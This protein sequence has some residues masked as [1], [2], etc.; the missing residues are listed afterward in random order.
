MSA[1]KYPI[2]V[3]LSLLCF[4]LVI[5]NKKKLAVS[6]LFFSLPFVAA[7]FKNSDLFQF[8]LGL[9]AFMVWSIWLGQMAHNVINNRKSINWSVLSPKLNALYYFLVIGALVA[10]YKGGG[11][12][13]TYGAPDGP[14]NFS[15]SVVNYSLYVLTVIL[16]IKIMVEY[17]FDR[18]SLT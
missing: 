18:I 9:N 13:L 5:F 11:S 16:F 6:A 4:L 3:L 14:M 8:K 12:F 7:P 17:E 15:E 10:L 2:L 1:T